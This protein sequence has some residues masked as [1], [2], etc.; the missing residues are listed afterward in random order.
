VSNFGGVGTNR[1]RWVH[2]PWNDTAPGRVIIEPSFFIFEAA[3]AWAL[4]LPQPTKI[5]SLLPRAAVFFQRTRA[6][7]FFRGQDHCGRQR[8]RANQHSSHLERS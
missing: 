5:R 4:R 7:T 2:L 1:A 8:R 6:I 3:S